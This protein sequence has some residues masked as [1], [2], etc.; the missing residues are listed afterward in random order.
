MKKEFKFIIT[1]LV[2]SSFFYILISIF[3]SENFPF[4]GTL[5]VAST[6]NKIVNFMGIETLIV[7]GTIYLRNNI[8]F[9]IILECTGVYEMIILTSVILSYPTGI[10]NKLYGIFVGIIIIYILNMFRLLSIFY[11]LVYY[12]EKFDFVDRYL[13]QVS[14]VIFILLAYTIWL[15]SLEFSGSS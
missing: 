12:T 15:K 14:L 6:L 8:A 7:D 9:K 1:F 11:V 10:I 2:F 13:W 4:I 3:Y 5:S